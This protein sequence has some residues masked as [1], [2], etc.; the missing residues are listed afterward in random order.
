VYYLDSKEL[1]RH[2]SAI[3][4]GD[5]SSFDYIYNDMKIPIFTIA[6][7]ITNSKEDAEDIVQ[8]VFIKLFTN[9]PHTEIKNPRAWIFKIASNLAIDKCR[10]QSKS[11]L[12]SVHEF[13]E[14]DNGLSFETKLIIEQAISKLPKEEIFITTLHL[15]AELKF[16][17]I[18]EILDVPLGTVLWKYRKAI[19][20]LRKNLS[21]EDWFL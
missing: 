18:A 9:P 17:E 7:R 19:E 3:R 8:E 10:K 14:T 1:A 11:V 5:K 6:C 13:I 4:N 16:R 12:T 15:N 21:K 2:F 20:E